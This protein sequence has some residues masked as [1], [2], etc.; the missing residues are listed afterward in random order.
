M[1]P[2]RFLVPTLQAAAAGRQA[3]AAGLC[4]M[5]FFAAARGMG[6]RLL[7]RG[8]GAGLELLSNPVD[9]TR[10]FEF[11]F[12][13]SAMAA[14][15]GDCLD[16]SSP[17]LLSLRAA[18]EGRARSVLMLNP[19]GRDLDYSLGIAQGLGLGRI[20][21]LNAGSEALPGLGRGFDTAWSVS[22]LEHI[23]GRGDTAAARSLKRCLRKGGRLILS[24]PTA[25]A[26]RETWLEDDPYGT[27][28]RRRGRVFFQRFYDERGLM[29][30]LV[31][32]L[33]PRSLKAA[34]W[35]EARPG[36]YD[37]LEAALKTGSL[38]A[39]AGQ[40]RDAAQGFR[41]YARFRDM[42]GVGVC[43]LAMDF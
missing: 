39:V 12:A 26:P 37:A 28:S 19:D 6:W 31:E 41:P 23:A 42:P 38:A 33:K 11:D 29:R 1:N 2:L 24:V 34:W 16:L 43:A 35:G 25:R 17:R 10:Y 13:W 15:A 3:R 5:D 4:G 7:L 18:A 9:L 8:R 27:L 22:V 32:P 36:T 40:S 14:D 30:R 20:R 21:G